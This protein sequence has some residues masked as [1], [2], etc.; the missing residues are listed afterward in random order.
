LGTR[1]YST[2]EK[3]ILLRGSVQPGE[4]KTSFNTGG[5]NLLLQR[6]RVKNPLCQKE[7]DLKRKKATRESDD[8]ALG[9]KEDNRQR[10]GD[11][12]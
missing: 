1:N 10:V 6:C 5:A 8:L 3:T 7:P 4:K 9:K 2:R 12:G 11:R